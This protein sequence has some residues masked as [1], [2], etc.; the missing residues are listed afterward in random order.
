MVNRRDPFPEKTQRDM[1]LQEENK[2][3]LEGIDGILL[4]V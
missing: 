1:L 4:F 3:S 2:D